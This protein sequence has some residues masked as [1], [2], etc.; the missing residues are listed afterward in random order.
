MSYLA[1]A[2]FPLIWM[3]V[4]CVGALVRTR[5]VR[6]RAK[7]REIRQRWWAMGALGFGS[8][9]MTVSFLA[10]PG[11]HGGSDRLHP[12]PVHVRDR[13]RQPRPGAPGLPGRFGLGMFLR[14]AVIGHLYQWIA[15]GDHAPGNVGGVL[16]NDILVRRS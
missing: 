1:Q 16:A 4:P 10:H 12:H 6:D 13:F 8:L 3:V 2:A 5:R 11:R 15:N 7:R 9:W 14:G